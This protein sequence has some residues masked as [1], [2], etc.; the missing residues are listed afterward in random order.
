M[1]AAERLLSS[2]PCCFF[3]SRLDKICQERSISVGFASVKICIGKVFTP[4]ELSLLQTLATD[5]ASATD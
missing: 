3:L 5:E 4:C 2:Q 1:V